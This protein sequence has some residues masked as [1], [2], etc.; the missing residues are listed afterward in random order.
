MRHR[1]S[2]RLARSRSG[3]H[4]WLVLSPDDYE[5]PFMRVCQVCGLTQQLRWLW[6]WMRSP[7]TEPPE[8]PC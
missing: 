5:R 7:K 2:E 4:R 8:R 1:V 3:S 6:F